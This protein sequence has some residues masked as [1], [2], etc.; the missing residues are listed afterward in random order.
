LIDLQEGENPNNGTTS[1][2]DV[3]ASL[4]QVI[5][6]TGINTW[7]DIMYSM[8]D[9]EN[10]V[11]SLF[12]IACVIFLNFWLANM[13]VPSRLLKAALYPAHKHCHPLCPLQLRRRH[14]QHLWEYPRGDKAQR[15][16]WKVVCA[17]APE[18]DVTT[19][20]TLS[21]PTYRK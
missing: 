8:V 17:S 20:L 21:P 9:A 7:T 5:I 12:S 10:K 4:M 15:F 19:A 2:D 14:H 16:R 1:F 13:C 6:L 11:S 3:A 18:G